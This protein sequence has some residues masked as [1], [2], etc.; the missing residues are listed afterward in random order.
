MSKLDLCTK[1]RLI[2]DSI[3]LATINAK[4]IMEDWEDYQKLDWDFGERPAARVT[5]RKI[6]QNLAILQEFT[7]LFEFKSEGE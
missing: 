2:R 3:D 1:L 6:K 7:K 4:K 5:V